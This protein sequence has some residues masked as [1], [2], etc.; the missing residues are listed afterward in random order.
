MHVVRNLMAVLHLI[1]TRLLVGF[2]ARAACAH[3][4][5]RPT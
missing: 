2:P 1:R 3:E 5:N 4:R